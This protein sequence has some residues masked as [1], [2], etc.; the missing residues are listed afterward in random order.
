MFLFDNL[1]LDSASAVPEPLNIR[2]FRFWNSCSINWPSSKNEQS[3]ILVILFRNKKFTTTLNT[4]LVLRVFLFIW[5][6]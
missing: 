6:D 3:L 2:S 1:A 4:S 5:I